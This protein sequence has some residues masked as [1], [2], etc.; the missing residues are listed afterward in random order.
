[1]QTWIFY[2]GKIRLDCY[3]LLMVLGRPFLIYFIGNLH[4]HQVGLEP[5]SSPSILLLWKEGPLKLEPIGQPR[6]AFQILNITIL[7]YLW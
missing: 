7:P 3:I 1:M 6:K 4:T 2:L 5:T